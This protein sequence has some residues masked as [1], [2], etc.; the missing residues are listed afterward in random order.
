MAVGSDNLLF[1]EAL[2]AHADRLEDILAQDWPAFR[3]HLLE[4]LE[5]LAEAEDDTHVLVA[6]DRLIE[7][8]LRSPAENLVR[9]LLKQSLK[10]TEQLERATR[11]VR[12]SDPT[13]GQTR[14][15]ELRLSAEADARNVSRLNVAAAS[16]KLALRLRYGEPKEAAIKEVE[17]EPYEAEALQEGAKEEP[18]EEHLEE[19]SYVNFTFADRTE[20]WEPRELAIHEGFRSEGNYKL[21]VSIAYEPDQRFDG[22]GE[23]PEI[24]RPELGE[25]TIDLYVALFT[26]RR[27]LI[28]VQGEPLAVLKWPSKGPSTDNAEF[29]LTVSPTERET[30]S[31]LDVYIYHRTNLLYT[32]RFK[33][34]VEPEDYEWRQDERP[35]RW[36]HREDDLENRSNLFRRFARTKQLHERGLNLAIQ[37][38]E[39]PDEYLLTAFMGRAE[40]PARLKMTR[41]ELNSNLVKMRTLM[42][43]LR[44]DSIYIEGGYT[45]DGKYIGN[46]TSAASGYSKFRDRVEAWKTRGRVFK[47][48][49]RKMALLGSQLFDNL[50]RSESAQL[51]CNAIQEHLQEGDIIQ[52]WVDEDASDFVYPWVW[53]YGK[54]IEGRKR[55]KV[56]KDLF[57]GYRYIIE[58]LPQ[59]PE[60]KIRPIGSYKLP[61]K[62]LDIKVGTFPFET[63]KAQ[64]EYFKALKQK[65]KHR[66][67]YEVWEWDRDWEEFLPKCDSQILYFF[68]H[69]HTSKPVTI[70][71]QY[72]YDMKT[73]WEEWL[74]EPVS[75]ESRAMKEYRERGLK[76]LKELQRAG[77]L[78][79][80]HIRLARGDLLLRELRKG[81][82]LQR[83][84]P[85]VFLN[86]CESAQVFPNI[87]GGLIDE[88]LKKGARDVIGTE[89]PMLP[90]FADLFSTKFFDALFY[91][92]DENDNPTSV[93]KVLLGLRREFLEV[94]NPLGFAY[95]L[96]GDA[97][98]R[99]SE[100][101]TSG[102]NP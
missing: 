98:T 14:N 60:T 3:D 18:I 91:L 51:L 7:T 81:M 64:K 16:R 43:D 87:S 63:T 42:D 31:T 28:R 19:A 46:Y 79:E 32:A 20:D 93:G 1:V 82:N 71:D 85:L 21:T 8:G 58:Q 89:I 40:L 75:E 37:S 66:V 70:S 68:S 69:G 12:F 74:K 52:I 84:N 94:G 29:L 15:I 49:M 59:Y 62:Q 47:E 10:V 2:L 4:T 22:P 36:L 39:R 61:S 41:D 80:T 101:L 54:T 73:K 67:E 76:A 27:S 13:S 65:N 30:T 97:T 11:S 25:E 34:T 38:S 72:F 17:I 9:S 102:D 50:F 48:F 57:W 95:T 53:L 83:S 90:Q 23:P 6:V 99:L 24:D 26:K 35:I 78:S 56:E 33:I 88:F 44:R 77:L 55:Q 45:S 86:M 92:V 96:F 100:S 5:L